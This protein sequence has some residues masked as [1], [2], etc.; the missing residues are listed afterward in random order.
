MSQELG[1]ER[2][3]LTTSTE[4]LGRHSEVRWNWG[5]GAFIGCSGGTLRAPRFSKA[6]DQPGRLGS[7]HLGRLLWGSEMPRWQLCSTVMPCAGLLRTSP[8]VAVR[9]WAS[10]CSHV[11]GQSTEVQA[12]GVSLTVPCKGTGFQGVR[13]QSRSLLCSPP[14]PP[15][16][17]LR[18]QGLA[19]GAT[20]S[21]CSCATLAS[22][23]T[24]LRLIYQVVTRLM[25]VGSEDRR[26]GLPEGEPGVAR[27]RVVGPLR[28]LR[29]SLIFLLDRSRCL[30]KPIS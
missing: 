2:G 28:P 7:G 22:G 26:E 14:P 24:S 19:P 18:I 17:E 27:G 30:G 21:L 3:S 4:P 8:G 5:V 20:P 15:S 12:G 13:W 1:L 29:C 10:P 9:I 16:P 11:P 6:G 25:S 23:K